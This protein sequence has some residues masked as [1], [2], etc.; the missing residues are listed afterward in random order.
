MAN[1]REDLI[2]TIIEVAGDELETAKD[3]EV[4]AKENELELMYRLM[5]IAQGMKDELNT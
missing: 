1:L 4:L 3:M 2:N 5:N